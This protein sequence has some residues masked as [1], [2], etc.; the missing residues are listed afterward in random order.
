MVESEMRQPL[1]G[2]QELLL[3]CKEL[4]LH[5]TDSAGFCLS[6]ALAM[7][8]DKQNGN[9]TQAG[10]KLGKPPPPWQHKDGVT[11]HHR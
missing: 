10:G 9:M 6:S 1:Q 3:P 8:A 11:E 5:Y 4:M 2:D 7:E